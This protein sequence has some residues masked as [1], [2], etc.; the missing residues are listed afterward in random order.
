MIETQT[1]KWEQPSHSLKS[2]PEKECFDLIQLAELTIELYQKVN[3]IRLNFQGPDYF[4]L[5]GN[6]SDLQ[7]LLIKMAE[8]L[9][10]VQSE[11][12][13]SRI[14]IGSNF[15]ERVENHLM[16]ISRTDAEKIAIVVV[17]LGNLIQSFKKSS[18]VSSEK[19]SF[20]YEGPLKNLLR[21]L[22]NILWI[23]TMFSKY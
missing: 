12:S 2:N 21:E 11:S 3:L 6:F 1:L 16:E 13:Q 23:F 20:Y 14:R 17:G 22:E 5:E 18:L 15:L 10:L 8:E 9:N 4:G 19:E 7:T